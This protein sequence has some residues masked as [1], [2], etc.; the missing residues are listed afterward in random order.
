MTY[1]ENSFLA[2]VSVG[3]TL[4]GW[5]SAGSG[6]GSV[7]TDSITPLLEGTIIEISSPAGKVMAHSC[8]NRKNLR[9][10]NLPNAEAIGKSAFSGCTALETFVAP[11]VSSIGESAFYVTSALGEV[12]FP[13][14]TNLGGSAFA[15]SGIRGFGATKLLTVPSR[16]F[17]AS[18]SLETVSIPAATLVET[19]AF[20]GCTALKEAVLSGVKRLGTHCFDGCESL[21]QVDLKSMDEIPT[22]YRVGF[23]PSYAFQNCK[24]LGKVDVGKG[25]A[26]LMTYAFFGCAALETLILRAEQVAELGTLAL[27]GTG[28]AKGTGYVYVPETVADGYKSN[29][30]WA[31]YAAQ[32]R[33]IEDYPAICG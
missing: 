27:S 30:K 4:K 24:T 32:I 29:S 7:I 33:A 3:R 18:T 19:Y 5:A 17:D 8:Y 13:K 23:I 20:N 9:S 15:S 6:G 22:G 2:G 31:T 21:Q 28:I 26:S 16:A 11:A 25:V 10:V 1:D 12:D 14:L